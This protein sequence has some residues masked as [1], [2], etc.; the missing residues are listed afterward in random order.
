MERRVLLSFLMSAVLAVSCEITY[1]NVDEFPGDDPQPVVRLDEVAEILAMVPLQDVHLEE[2]HNAVM[3]SSSNGYDEE[4]T[5]R[6]LFSAPGTGV[7]DKEFRS[8]THYSSPLYKLIEE[9]VR[10]MS[11]TKA[12]S[13]DPDEFLGMLTESDVQ[14]YWPYSEQ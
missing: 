10:A 5:M 8:G 12:I 14:I 7:G 3:S 2:V 6:H 9:Q 4:Y 1:N 13:M 11:A